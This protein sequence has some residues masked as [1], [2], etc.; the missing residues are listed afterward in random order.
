MLS[1]AL[2]YI[3]QICFVVTE[4]VVI[5]KDETKIIADEAMKN[6]DEDQG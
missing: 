3:K 1:Y 2:L 4:C 5:G 6:E